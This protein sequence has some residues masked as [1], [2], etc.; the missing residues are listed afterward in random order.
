MDLL[1]PML[2]T[3]MTTGLTC[4]TTCGACSNPLINVFLST[5]LFT[6]TGKLKNCL[7]AFCT[8]YIGKTISIVLLCIMAS[9][10]GS[11]IVDENEK[12]FGINFDIIVLIAMFLLMIYYIIVWYKKY[13][14]KAC[15]R[16]CKKTDEKRPMLIS[17]FI[18]G[19]SP[20]APL[21]LAITYA[22]I[23]SL[24]SAIIIGVAFSFSNLI[25]PM[26][27][28]VILTGVLS[29]EMFKELGTK[30][31]YFELATYVVFAIITASSIASYI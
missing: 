19:L 2:I 8:F 25:L 27:I 7:L 14:S 9:F 4:G 23:N 6:H 15:N 22:S 30:V 31:K 3:T 17:G 5:Y 26:I 16:S 11:N 1:F 18:S 20:C 10:L 13:N 28:L 21:I 12:I 29:K 24:F